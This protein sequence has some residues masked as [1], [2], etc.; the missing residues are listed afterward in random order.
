[1]QNIPVLYT[2]G[3]TIPEAYEKSLLSLMFNGC[4]IKTQ[5]DKPEDLPSIDATMDITIENPEAEPSIYKLFP[6][7]I[8][9]LR[10]YVMELQGAKDDWV[11]NVDDLEDRRWDYTYHGRLAKWGRWKEKD[12]GITPIYTSNI[13]CDGPINQ[14]DIVIKNLIDAPY[15]RRAQAITW[16]PFIDNDIADPPCLQ[17]MWFR[18]LEEKDSSY[19]LNTNIRFRSNDAWGAAF[20]NMWGITKFIRSEIANKIEKETGRIINMGRL[21][22]HADSYHIYGKDINNAADRFLKRVMTTDFS[23]RVWNF[24][25]SEIQEA[26]H[27]AEATIRKKIDDYNREHDQ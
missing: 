17:S 5:Y 4:K 12:S 27:E 21:N 6:G 1:M 22:W 13:P 16:M 8:E 24:N 23:D 15:T 11:R 25:D 19:T 3:K 7:G 9:D 20:M 26:W 2:S 18:M 10:E 14:I